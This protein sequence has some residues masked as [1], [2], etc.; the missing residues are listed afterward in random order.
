M[1][2]P[3]IL[4]VR[5]ARAL[6]ERWRAD[7][8]DGDLNVMNESIQ[9]L[10]VALHQLGD[11]PFQV[12]AAYAPDRNIVGLAELCDKVVLVGTAIVSSL[13]GIRGE[14]RLRRD[15]APRVDFRHRQ[16]ALDLAVNR[17]A[18]LSDR[19]QQAALDD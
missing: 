18:A 11:T 1:N 12:N 16:E 5:T 9:L 13:E 8:F 19:R 4:L 17:L 15:S 7:A 14:L 6:V 3:A 10:A 2:E